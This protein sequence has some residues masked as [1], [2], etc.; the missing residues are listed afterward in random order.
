MRLRELEAEQS[1]DET[2]RRVSGD[3][4][5]PQRFGDH[6]VRTDEAVADRVH[7]VVDVAD[8][9]GD[10]GLELWEQLALCRRLHRAEQH[11]RIAE[12]L[13]Q[14]VQRVGIGHVELTE[15]SLECVRVRLEARHV[16]LEQ[17]LEPRPHVR[18]RQHGVPRH[19]VHAHPQAQVVLRQAPLFA[20]L[21]DVAEQDHQV[22]TRRPRD[23]EVVLAERTAR[24]MA[25][26][27]ADR[28]AQ[29]HGTEG[30]HDAAE[31]LRH[32]VV[33]VR[34]VDLARRHRDLHAT[35]QRTCQ[36]L[37]QAS[38][39]VERALHPDRAGDG[40]DGQAAAGRRCRQRR[41][42]ADLELGDPAQLFELDAIEGIDVRLGA[43]FRGDRGRQLAG[44][45]PVHRALLLQHPCEVAEQR[46][47][48][49]GVIA[50]GT[51]WTAIAHRGMVGRCRRSSSAARPTRSGA[52]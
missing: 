18:H 10:D 47:A 44:G 23:R 49:E 2:V 30:L 21:V 12:Q 52:A 4:P 3:A 27:R 39:R 26:Q 11:L 6:A 16:A 8:H 48:L 24:E 9:D 29:H 35:R 38:V 41:G 43:A 5:A 13:G 37:E 28:H 25:E 51:E 45:I 46:D 34:I 33:E 36:R 31:H 40:L 22:V 17:R 19:L 42:V 50:L 14:L 20:E 15:S 7:H 32:R 1:L